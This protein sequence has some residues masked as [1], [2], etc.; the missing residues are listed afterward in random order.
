MEDLA[1]LFADEDT[2]IR[3]Y[4]AIKGARVMGHKYMG[5]DRTLAV[6]FAKNMDIA[7]DEEVLWCLVEKERGRAPLLYPIVSKPDDDG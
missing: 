4:I 5:L 3:G 1:D 7:S 6:S 2:V